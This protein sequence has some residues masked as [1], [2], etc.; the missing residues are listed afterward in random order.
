MGPPAAPDTLRMR[1]AA[2]HAVRGLDLLAAG[3]WPLLVS[4]IL[5]LFSAA[6]ASLAGFNPLAS[7]EELRGARPALSAL[8]SLLL[9][10]SAAAAVYGLS[11]WSQASRELAA[12]EAGA[13]V[14]LRASQAVE[15]GAAAAAIGILVLGAGLYLGEPLLLASRALLAV[16]AGLTGAGWAME[17]YFYLIV[18]P[19]MEVSGSRFSPAFR[20]V[21]TLLVLLA[22]LIVAGM[23]AGPSSPAGLT[24]FATAGVVGVVLVAILLQAV[25]ESKLALRKV[26]EWGG[27]PPPEA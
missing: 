2:E 4:L 20:W 11:S 3:S 22:V 17:V 15:L 1:A 8:S 16:G 19:R 6:T 7:P 21:G 27:L 12:V 24:L 23:L 18:L 5:L 25:D 26:I 10:L 13:L 14:G 9:G